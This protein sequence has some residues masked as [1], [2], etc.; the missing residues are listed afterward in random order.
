MIQRNRYFRKGGDMAD[1]RTNRTKMKPKNNFCNKNK[2]IAILR[3]G[4]IHPNSLFIDIS[5]S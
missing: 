4:K 2:F 5:S 1:G 3:G